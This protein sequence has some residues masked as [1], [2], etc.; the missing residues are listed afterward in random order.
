[1]MIKRLKNILFVDEIIKNYKYHSKKNIS[2]RDIKENCINQNF[3]K[4]K[5]YILDT[6]HFSDDIIYRNKQIIQKLATY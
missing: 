2:V 5:Y 3:Q 6:G 1:M 4:D